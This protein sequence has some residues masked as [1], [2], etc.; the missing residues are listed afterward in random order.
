MR[1]AMIAPPWLP[2]PPEAYGGTEAVIDVL[3]RGLEKLGHE[4][5]L[6]TTGDSKSSLP[7]Y[8]YFEHALGTGRGDSAVLELVHVIDSYDKIKDFDIVHDHTL[9]GPIFSAWNQDQPVVT[10]NHAPFTGNYLDYLYSTIGKK[11]PIIAISHHHANTAPQLNIISVIHHGIDL[12]QFS[13]GKGNGGYIVFLGRMNPDKGAHTAIEV[14]RNAGI[15]LKI[16]AKCREGTEV[17]YFK[18]YIKPLLSKD[19][20]YVGE[21]NFNEKIELLRNAICLINPI[22][23]PEPFGMVMI[24][25]LACGTPVI[26]TN[27]GSVPEIIENGVNGFI[28]NSISELAYSVRMSPALDRTTCRKIAEERF[29]Q[30]IMTRRHV[31]TYQKV[32]DLKKEGKIRSTEISRCGRNTKEIF[33]D[34]HLDEVV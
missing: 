11:V 12:G 3:S 27:H 8:G 4:V 34:S 32:I 7:K 18:S 13:F 33:T 10:T 28:A 29:S 31:E 24:E 19:I 2:I 20:E 23:W 9:L 26:A 16:A 21:V 22:H 6:F 1:I 25:A 30:E 17:E 15:P 14:A 5:T